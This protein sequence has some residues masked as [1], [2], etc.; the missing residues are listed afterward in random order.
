MLNI[1]AY[2]VDDINLLESKLP[3]PHARIMRWHHDHDCVVDSKFH[4]C[5]STE[6]HVTDTDSVVVRES[7]CVHVCVCVTAYVH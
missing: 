4:T 5:T 6:G 3:P 1:C 2:V 7:V